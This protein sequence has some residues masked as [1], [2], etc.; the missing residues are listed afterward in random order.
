M[1]TDLTPVQR[2]AIQTETLVLR[3]VVEAINHDI[4][5]AMND[6][7]KGTQA[8]LGMIEMAEAFSRELWLRKQVQQ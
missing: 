8:H 2:V 6:G 4:I 1:I 5:Q 7:V 3:H